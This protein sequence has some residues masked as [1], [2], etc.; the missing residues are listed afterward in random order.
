MNWPFYAITCSSDG[1]RFTIH[2]TI[3]AVDCSYL[4]GV[5]GW[6]LEAGDGE[7]CFNAFHSL[8]G[9][10]I[11]LYHI[12]HRV[13]C[14]VSIVVDTVHCPPRTVMLEE[15]TSD[16]LMHRSGSSRWSCEK[17]NCI[18]MNEDGHNSRY[19]IGHLLLC[20]CVTSK[21]AVTPA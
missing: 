2:S 11:T 17:I 21:S 6:M 18:L 15:V 5:R 10:V 7:F 9:A 8:P 1:E 12:S 16:T 14:Y 20:M 4:Y 19:C 3:S 13:A